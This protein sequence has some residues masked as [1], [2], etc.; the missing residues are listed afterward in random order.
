[1][2]FGR[3]NIFWLLLLVPGLVAFLWWSWRVRQ[4]LVLQFIQ[5]RLLPS[6]TV[7]ISPRREKIRLACIVACAPCLIVAL[8]KLQI[9]VYWQ[10]VQRSGLD[11]VIAVD[12]T[13]SMLAED[14]TPNPMKQAKLV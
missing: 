11:I 3:P 12:S 1:M 8:A 14:I 2:T 7:G 10:I 13:E 4:R 6:L 5:S 9:G